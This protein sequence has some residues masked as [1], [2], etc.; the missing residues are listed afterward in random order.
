MHKFIVLVLVAALAALAS[1]PV[2]QAAVTKT[3]LTLTSAF[4][5][6]G[7]SFWDGKIKSSRA[8]CANKRTVTVY[9][10][11]GKKIG[12]AK[13]SRMLNGKGYHWTVAARLFAKT[14]SRY[15]AVVKATRSCGGAKSK[16][17]R[18]N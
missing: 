4:P 2:A 13:S 6:N 8:A 15:Y 18:V 9:T 14:G 3:T 5:G 11:A 16:V 12:S 7:Q 1:A 10:S 17:F